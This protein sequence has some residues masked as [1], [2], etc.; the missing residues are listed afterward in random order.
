MEIDPND[1][2]A[3]TA[4]GKTLISMNQP[5]KAQQMFER[6]IQIDPTNYLAHYRLGTL[7]R[8]T[9]KTEEAKQQVAEYLKYKQMK[10]KLEKIFHDMRVLSGH[11]VDEDQEGK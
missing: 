2:D 9:G 8:Q 10:E 11:N 1:G 6:A 7:Y 5:E 3:V 4:V